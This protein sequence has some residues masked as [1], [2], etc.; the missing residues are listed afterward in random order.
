MCALDSVLSG[1]LSSGFD[2][3]ACSHVETAVHFR[4]FLGLDV[5][6]S[7]S[8]GSDVLSEADKADESDKRDIFNEDK[9]KNLECR[10]EYDIFIV[11]K[12]IFHSIA[13]ESQ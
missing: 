4:L 1:S 8:E 11:E 3:Q 10:I 6:E 13:I 7:D 9:M 12:S 2:G 5:E